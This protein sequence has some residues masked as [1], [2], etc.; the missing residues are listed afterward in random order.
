M[1]TWVNWQAELIATLGV[2]L[3]D[4]LH[5]VSMDDVDWRAWHPYYAEGRSP[6]EAVDRA[7]ERDL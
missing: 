1:Q 3:E 4:V 5:H 6:R 2:E 7:L